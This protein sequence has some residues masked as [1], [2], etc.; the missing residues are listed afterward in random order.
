MTPA[1]KNIE[2]DPEAMLLV[3]KLHQRGYKAADV[4]RYMD[5]VEHAI[6]PFADIERRWFDPRE[7]HWVTK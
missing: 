4:R 7:P 3:A 5:Q 2:D 1:Q 6:G